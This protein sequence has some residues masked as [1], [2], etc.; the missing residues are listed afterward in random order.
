MGLDM[1]LSAK[2]YISSFS[3]EG[4]EIAA[5]IK[6]EQ[7]K[8]MGSME[9]KYLICEA[10]YWRKAN[11]IHRWFVD[12]VQDGADECKPHYVGTDQLRELL[13]LCEKVLANRDQ[14]EELLPVA[15]GFFFGSDA[16]DDGYFSDIEYTIKGLRELLGNKELTDNWDF[17]YCSSW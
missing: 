1:Y 13:G 15:E 4:K 6:A 7:I 11:Q 14:A 5:V 12:N 16:Y 8:G 3:D 9:P 17:E 2:K 10:M